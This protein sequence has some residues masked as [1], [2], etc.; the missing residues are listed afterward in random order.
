MATV[1]QPVVNELNTVLVQLRNELPVRGLQTY[2]N[3][4]G[5]AI[6]RFMN[7]SLRFIFPLRFVFSLRFMNLSLRSILHIHIALRFMNL[8]F[9][10]FMNLMWY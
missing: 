1:L 10:R 8:I 3:G 4:A 7:P 6:L 5:I 9:L 2:A